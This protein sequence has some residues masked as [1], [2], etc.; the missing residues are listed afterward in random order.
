MEMLRPRFIFLT[1]QQFSFR[2][3]CVT[4]LVVTVIGMTTISQSIVLSGLWSRDDGCLQT[5]HT[6]AFILQM[7]Y[8]LLQSR[9]KILELMWKSKYQ[10]AC[11]PRELTWACTSCSEA[12]PLAVAL[13]KFLPRGLCCA[14][15]PWGGGR[16]W[17]DSLIAQM[18]TSS[19]NPNCTCGT[20]VQNWKKIHN[21]KPVYGRWD[22]ADRLSFEF[23]CFCRSYL[24]SH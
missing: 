9:N 22:C 12:D 17:F 21:F 5:Y 13:V 20:L 8:E 10:V 14:L 2:L 19:S 18:H 7:H 1:E 11:D 23:Y 24:L 6:H 3:Y 4:V 16:C 15:S